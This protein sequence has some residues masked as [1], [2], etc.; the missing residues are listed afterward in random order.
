MKI[1]V[2][3]LSIILF[4][5]VI[6]ALSLSDFVPSFLDSSNKNLESSSEVKPFVDVKRNASSSSPWY[7]TRMQN[8]VSN[9]FCDKESLSVAKAVVYGNKSDNTKMV[10]NA[11]TT[12]ETLNQNMNQRV[13][14]FQDPK[15]TN[16]LLRDQDQIQNSALIPI[17][18][19]ENVHMDVNAQQVQFNIKY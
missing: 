5:G 15:V 2:F 9:V 13:S 14:T 1:W 7:C 4:C 6:D 17:Q 12:S 19:S 10:D 3:F 18:P 11:V 8:N 16:L